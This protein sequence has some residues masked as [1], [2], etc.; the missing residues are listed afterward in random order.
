MKHRLFSKTT[1]G[2]VVAGAAM[3][4]AN[5]AMAAQP[6]MNSIADSWHNL[7][8]NNI[9]N[10][11]PNDSAGTANHS[12]ATGEICVFCHTPHGGDV[13]A[14]VPLWNRQLGDP[15]SYTRYSANGTTTFDA[16]EDDI[17]SVTIACLS[18]HDGAQAI[19]ALLNAPG[20]G[21][22]Y[23]PGSSTEAQRREW[24]GGTAMSGSD[25][26][27]DSR[28]LGTIVQNLGTDLSNDHPVSMQYAGGGLAGVDGVISGTSRDGDFTSQTPRTITK[29]DSTTYDVFLDAEASGNSSIN[30]VFWIER[31]SES[32]NPTGRDRS[33]VIFYT[34]NF[35]SQAPGGANG[36]QPFVECGSCHDPHNVDNPTFLRVSNGI[37]GDLT[38]T[39][40]DAAN[41]A[42]SGLCLT[43]HDK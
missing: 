41:D 30:T 34:R 38:T 19:D 2:M 16:E 9:K 15:A 26:G 18:C 6:Q 25:V 12:T 22:Y 24:T 32:Q 23:A 17:G 20:S 42:A 37:A 4:A 7:G 28:L 40:P 35:T 11:T 10:G 27:G 31:G 5:S 33:D 39:F 13:S 1:I 14:A 8:A 29:A 3:I 43:C 21:N 36:F